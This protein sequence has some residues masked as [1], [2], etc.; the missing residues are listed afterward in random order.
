MDVLKDFFNVFYLIM[1]NGGQLS[2]IPGFEVSLKRFT[3]SVL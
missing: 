3:K 1:I 2:R